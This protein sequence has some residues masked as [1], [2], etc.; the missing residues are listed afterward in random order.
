MKVK[1][2]MTWDPEELAEAKPGTVRVRRKEGKKAEKGNGCATRLD[3]DRIPGAMGTPELQ[4]KTSRASQH[5]GKGRGGWQGP[6]TRQRPPHY[7]GVRAHGRIGA[8]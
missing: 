7:R 4:R 5:V 2:K 8:R 1:M 6:H 3:P